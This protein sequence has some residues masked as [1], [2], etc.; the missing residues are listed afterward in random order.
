PGDDPL[1]PRLRRRGH[2]SAPAPEPD[3][4]H[5]LLVASDPF[6][7]PT[8][9]YHRCPLARRRAS[10]TFRRP[11]RLHARHPRVRFR[12]IL[13]HELPPPRQLRTRRIHLPAVHVLL[14]TLFPRL[15]L[16]GDDPRALR[17]TAP[18]Y[19]CR[20]RDGGAS[21]NP[22]LLA[23]FHRPDNVLAATRCRDRPSVAPADPRCGCPGISPR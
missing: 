2:P 21:G 9:F 22:V 6:T 14:W 13:R 12:R 17:Q 18:A 15:R 16:A 23:W 10:P 8:G 5:I 11:V 7:G 1:H 4:R 19:S 3:Q 20:L